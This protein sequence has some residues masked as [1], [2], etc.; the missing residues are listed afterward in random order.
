[1]VSRNVKSAKEKR[2]KVVDLEQEEKHDPR[3]V[4]LCKKSHNRSV[5][6]RN[7]LKEKLKSLK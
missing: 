5:E 1:M 4:P 6:D 7:K 2:T 3:I